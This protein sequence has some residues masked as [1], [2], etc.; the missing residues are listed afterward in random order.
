MFAIYSGA[1]QFAS[2]Q[3][4][5]ATSYWM[6]GWFPFLLQNC[7]IAWF[8]RWILYLA[9]Y[10]KLWYPFSD[11]PSHSSVSSIILHLII[12]YQY[13]HSFVMNYSFIMCFLYNSCVWKS[14][15]PAEI[16]A[17]FDAPRTNGKFLPRVWLLLIAMVSDVL[18]DTVPIKVSCSFV[19]L[20]LQPNGFCCAYFLWFNVPGA[21][22]M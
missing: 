3:I 19:L 18:L 10:F 7:H 16:F 6:W 4:E 8:H 21:H 22:Y 5:Y 15:I 1:C 13:F 12:I 14:K 2:K 11:F 17:I 9:V 20:S